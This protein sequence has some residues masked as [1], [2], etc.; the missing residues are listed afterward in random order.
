[1]AESERAALNHIKP[2]NDGAHPS[3]IPF[4]LIHVAAFAAIFTGV[5]LSDVLICVGLY[6]LRMWAITAGY[7]RYFSHRSFKTSRFFQFI[8]AFLAMTSAQRGVLWWAAHHRG[9]HR[10]SDTAEDLHSPFHGG[11]LHAHFGWILLDKNHHTD[12]DSIR[13]FAKYPELVWLDRNPYLPPVLLA[14]AVF[15]F[16]GLPGLVVGF[17]WSTIATW[18]ST[19]FINSLAH[20]HGRQ[21]FVTG[22]HSRNN[23]ALAILTLG[24]GWHNNHH[25]FPSSARQGFRWWEFDFTFLVL[26][27]LSFVGIVWDL[28]PPPRELVKGR[29][30]VGP[31]ILEKAAAQLVREFALKLEKAKAAWR[32]PT[33][34]E[35]QS[36]A[37]RRRMPLKSPHLPEI[38][39]RALA[40]ART[41]A[42]G[43]QLSAA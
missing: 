1:M 30:E 24:E 6:V 15:A 22:D 17:V 21:R 29:Q 37:R 25:A 14:A 39:E 2:T 26:R 32:L 34:E 13:D 28:R 23:W 4:L 43:P 3:A 35:L 9:H 40:I 19:F 18:H 20:V 12:Y 8:L 7:H 5:R 41:Y 42:Q 16:A 36:L 33:I 10:H 38:F 11:F 27:L 31:A